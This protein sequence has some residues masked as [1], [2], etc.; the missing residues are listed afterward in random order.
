MTE[1]NYKYRTSLVLLRNQFAGKGNLQ[2]PVIPKFKARKDG[3]DGLRR[4]SF[5]NT[6]GKSSS[7]IIRLPDDKNLYFMKV[8]EFVFLCLKECLLAAALVCSYHF[9]SS[10]PD[11][12]CW[13][14]VLAVNSL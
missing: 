9:G 8:S 13:A 7:V 1:E 2:I 6:I 12:F 5:D 10:F 11:F 14:S 3:F 4:I